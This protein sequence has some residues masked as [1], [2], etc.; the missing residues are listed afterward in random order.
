VPALATAAA[1]AYAANMAVLLAR[2]R[3]LPFAVMLAGAVSLAA[4]G[5]A[6]WHFDA[7]PRVL[8]WWIAFLALTIG[9]ER[10]EI[11]RFQRFST[12]A[13]VTGIVA[14]ALVLAGP[15]LAVVDLDAGARVLGGGLL[16][17]TGWLVRR[18]I[19]R[20]TV[21]TDGLARFVAVGIL[22]GYVWLAIAGA[23]LAAWAVPVGLRY[24]AAVHVFFVG[25][26]FGA[27]VAHE[28]IILP[29]VTGSA[30]HYSPLL[31]LPLAALHGSLLWRVAADL[32]G[33]FEQR[34]AAGLLQVTAIL[35][36]LVV[37]G[38]SALRGRRAR[39]SIAGRSAA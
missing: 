10:L 24:D 16:V 3:A 26:V 39:G 18:D 25:F 1:V 29:S 31:Y 4:G 11:M 17:A 19:A 34:R 27:I 6:W 21:R 28:P 14:L 9:A 23:L 7:V 12:G 20:R 30:F 37:S 33:T 38:V 35:L 36:F 2:H 22:S 8:P 13:R 5:I 15:P 32:A